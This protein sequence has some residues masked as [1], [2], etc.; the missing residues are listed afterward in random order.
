MSFL[1]ST[2]V[3][4]F[5]TS[6]RQSTIDINAKMNT[7]HNLI[8]II[9]RLTGKH[10]FVIDGL[11]I[12]SSGTYGTISSGSCNL[13]GYIFYITQDTV[14]PVAGDVTYTHLALQIK[15]KRAGVNDS[16]IIAFDS[17]ESLDES[18]L[19]KGLSLEKV[20]Y[21]TPDIEVVGNVTTYT[22]KLA[23]WGDDTKW[24][25]LYSNDG[26]E[27][28]RPNTLTQWANKIAIH[29]IDGDLNE[30]NEEEQDLETFLLYNMSM[31]DGEVL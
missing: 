9:N 15:V 22:L 30:Y 6:K 2:S 29:G 25:T 18:S 24:H 14:I 28:I 26:A 23:V 1:N 8:N 20:E 5:P 17:D 10:A 4:M 13:H 16:T 21:D 31:D 3:K 19:F 27:E 7:E 11:T 12:S